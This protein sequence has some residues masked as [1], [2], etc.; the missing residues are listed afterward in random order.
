LYLNK[1]ISSNYAA[2]IFPPRQFPPRQLRQIYGFVFDAIADYA[3]RQ[4][5]ARLTPVPYSL[6]P[7]PCSLFPVPCSLFP[8]TNCEI[9]LGAIARL[10]RVKF[11]RAVDFLG[12]RKFSKFSPILDFTS[13]A[14]FITKWWLKA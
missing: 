12:A 3:A 7:V 10:T 5:S 14:I 1:L 13:L 11:P 8:V 9:A 4:I 6:F 2:S